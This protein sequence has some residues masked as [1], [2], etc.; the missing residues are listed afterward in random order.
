MSRNRIGLLAAGAVIVLVV[1]AC[2]GTDANA[3]TATEP[4]STAS[5]TAAA[6]VSPT[7]TIAPTES[8]ILAPPTPELLAGTV[9]EIVPAG[10]ARRRAVF[11]VRWQGGARGEREQ[12]HDKCEGRTR[13]GEG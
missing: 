13:R 10:F 11:R 9:V 3:A 1:A 7:P 6:L 12:P 4:E 2:G 8:P 5:P